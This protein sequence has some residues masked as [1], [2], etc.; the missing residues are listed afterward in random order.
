MVKERI[1]NLI[2]D[3]KIIKDEENR[4]L[5]E[6]TDQHPYFSICHILLARG[7]LN[8]ESLKYNQKLKTAGA[9]SINRLKLFNLITSGNLQE[10][11]NN[12]T[13][14][15]DLKIGGPIRFKEDERYS[16][17]EWLSITETRKIKRGDNSDKIDTF[18][19]SD[20]KINVKKNEFFSAPISARESLIEKND[21][22]TETLAR[23]YLE[24]HHFEKAIE[25]YEKLILKY[26]KKSVFFAEKI[27]LIN[28][29]K[30]QNK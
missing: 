19:A 8:T 12:Q 3:P 21:I 29:I 13:S 20:P 5:I 6:I 2:E 26:P 1:I 7:L 18:I 30:E 11:S 15:K 24:Q 25:S 16:F 14:Q 17:S 28:K 4:Q 27:D 10:K 9:Y 22:V 23:V